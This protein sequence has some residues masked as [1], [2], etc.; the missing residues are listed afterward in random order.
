M[1]KL[2][3][4]V[5]G[6]TLAE[7][8]VSMIITGIISAAMFRAYISQH[9][10]WNM[11]E[12]VI[13]TQQ[14]TRAAIDELTRQIRMTGYGLPTGLNAL[15]VYDTNPDTIIV[16]YAANECD[17][18]IQHAMPQPSAELRCDGSDVSCFSA[19]QE[20]YIFDPFTETGEFFVITNVQTG[21]SH[22]QHNLAPLS[23][24]YPL[25]SKVIAIDRV[26]FYI[27]YTD[28]LH[29]NLMVKV[30]AYAPQVYAENITDLQFVYTLKNGM[31]VDAP[32]IVNDIRQVAIA[33]TG[34][35]AEPNVDIANQPY[36]YR[37]YQSNVNLRNF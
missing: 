8:M 16:I 32:S 11:Q 2:L 23:R 34:R 3:K 9:Q 6:I 22:I 10:A 17:A 29:P 26:K 35:T 1:K 33:V 4:S 27:D 7:V 5:R 20:S 13:E 30:G 12:A 21:S 25:G 19:G 36:R 31:T 18:P 14:N 28:N 37:D 15:E 24:A